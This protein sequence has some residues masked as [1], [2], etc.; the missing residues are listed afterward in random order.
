MDDSMTDGFGA[1]DVFKAAGW[2]GASVVSGELLRYPDGARAA[3][4]ES[5]YGPGVQFWTEPRNNRTLTECA[6]YIVARE[7]RAP[8]AV[9]TQDRE[10][11][12]FQ[13]VMHPSGVG[14][15]AGMYGSAGWLLL[16]P[17][18]AL[19]PEAG[20]DGRRK[21]EAALYAAGVDYPT[22]A[23]APTP[24]PLATL[25]AEVA[26]LSVTL[27]ATVARV[28]AL[29]SRDDVV[30]EVAAQDGAMAS[31]REAV[32]A[33][34]YTDDP[35]GAAAYLRANGF[36]DARA[37]ADA[38]SYGGSRSPAISAGT[39]WAPDD[40]FKYCRRNGL[41]WLDSARECVRRWGP[42]ADVA[43]LTAERD[44]AR[45]A[46]ADA[47]AAHGRIRAALVTVGADDPVEPA[48]VLVERLAAEVA[49]LR[50]ARPVVEVAENDEDGR[51]GVRVVLGD[52]LVFFEGLR[53]S[54]VSD[55]TYAFAFASQQVADERANRWRV[56]LGAA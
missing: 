40:P 6:R 21:A 19:G 45:S 7:G 53:D 37:G 18:G 42:S 22:E 5:V 28:E 4:A 38:V 16:V 50:A 35:E 54:L 8:R 25:R 12:S 31:E 30:D 24:D 13:N 27:A 33:P 44:E 26:A 49:R 11:G 20:D 36:P 46:H 17:P 9:W 10:I 48:D 32:P 3:D 23:A 56:R 43:R 29:E 14:R 55:P 47:R 15:L 1:I 39:I 2:A 52:G 51:Y 34:T 41:G